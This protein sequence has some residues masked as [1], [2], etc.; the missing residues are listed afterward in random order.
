MRNLFNIAT[1]A[2]ALVGGAASSPARAEGE[3]V[4]GPVASTAWGQGES[5]TPLAGEIR[6]GNANFDMSRQGA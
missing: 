3:Y 1:L 4:A 6:Q 5:R 2:A